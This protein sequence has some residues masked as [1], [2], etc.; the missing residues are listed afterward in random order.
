[1]PAA[2]TA[3]VAASD[4]MAIGATRALVAMGRRV[5]EDVS[6]IGFDDLPI[7]ALV[8]PELTTLRQ[9]P[10]RIG[11]AA[12]DALLARMDGDGAGRRTT[13]PVEL[14]VRASTARH[15]AA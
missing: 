8:R 14:M 7:A 13:I 3:I 1:V 2:P 6:V 15:S 5:P 11:A 12:A 9:D 4:L 10:M